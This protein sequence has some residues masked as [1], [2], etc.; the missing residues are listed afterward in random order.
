MI[1]AVIIMLVLSMF[2]TLIRCIKS[3]G[4]YDR[5]LTANVFGTQTIALIAL[6]GFISEELMLL[7]IALVYALIN[8]ITTIAFLKYFKNRSFR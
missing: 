8:F 6:L 5:I 1:E 2:L 7:D 3:E 4:T